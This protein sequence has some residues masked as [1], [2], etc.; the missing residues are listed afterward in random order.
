MTVTGGKYE[1]GNTMSKLTASSATGF[2]LGAPSQPQDVPGFVT[3]VSSNPPLIVNCP[4]DDGPATV[5]GGLGGWDVVQIPNARAFTEWQGVDLEALAVP[6]LLDGLVARESQEPTIE[7]LIQLGSP[8]SD[9]GEPPVLAVGG[10]VPHRRL[11]WVLQ[12]IDW[13]EAIWD[14]TV[15]V[16]QHAVLNLLRFMA[17]DAIVEADSG[18]TTGKGAGKRKTPRT[19]SY[20]VHAGD[21]LSGIAKKKMGAT[22]GAEVRAAVKAL[23]AANKI[24]DPNNIKTGLKLKIP[25]ASLTS[26]RGSIGRQFPHVTSS[27]LTDIELG[28]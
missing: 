12:S 4:L 20:T 11:K 3:L 28:A 8:S 18:T 5:S 15:R 2:T 26:T 25:A 16:R 17:G 7:A 1:S 14:G 22:T 6:I 21:T 27:G 23:Q 9:G 13:G 24:R 10:M 19:G